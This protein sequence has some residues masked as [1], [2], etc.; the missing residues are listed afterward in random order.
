MYPVVVFVL[1]ASIV[2]AHKKSDIPVYVICFNQFAYVHNMVEQLRRFTNNIVLVDNNSELPELIAYYD[3]L[4]N[5]TSVQVLRLDENHGFLVFHK[6]NLGANKTVFAMTD[7]DLQ[8]HPDT[9]ID[10]LDQLADLTEEF[11]IGKAGVALNISESL[12]FCHF[13]HGFFGELRQWEKQFW[14]YPVYSR[15]NLPVYRAP[16]DTTLAVHNTKYFH[17]LTRRRALRVAGKFTAIHLPWLRYLPPHLQSEKNNQL[18]VKSKLYMSGIW[19]AMLKPG[20][21]CE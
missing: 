8:L 7:P 1:L 21:D 9:P 18:Y 4:A 5:D 19:S 20:A 10:F 3:S 13:E 14:R 16:I 11:K 6:L 12:D 17:M 15:S 2:M